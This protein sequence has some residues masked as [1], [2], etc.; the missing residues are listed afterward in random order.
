V[1]VVPFP[2]HDQWAALAFL[3]VSLTD[4]LD[5]AVARRT[6]QV[7]A[8]GKLLDPFAD[9][10]LIISV[11]FVLVQEVLLPAWV[12]IVITARELLITVFRSV[13]AAQGTIIAATPFGKTKTV[14][15]IAAVELLILQRPYPELATAAEVV[16]AA[17]LA[18]T[19]YSGCD[20]IWRF[21]GVLSL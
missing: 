19:V 14:S 12:A 8:L 5:G 17:A 6:G 21:R 13:A 2:A 3:L 20:Y 15:Q 18:F 9:K 11:L 16:V 10:V 7:T 4:T 1:L